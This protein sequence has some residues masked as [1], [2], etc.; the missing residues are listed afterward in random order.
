[1]DRP[2]QIP[3]AS[4]GPPLGIYAD[5]CLM[6]PAVAALLISIALPHLHRARELDRRTICAANL[7]AYADALATYAYSDKVAEL[8]PAACPNAHT[9]NYVLIPWPG[10]GLGPR[11]IIAYE[12][13]ENH[14]DGGNVLYANGHVEWLTREGDEKH[15]KPLQTATATSAD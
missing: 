13:L 15:V 12:P 2:P 9:S 4:K 10:I 6:F 14:G 7:K 1:M 8:K 5:L 3:P 11:S